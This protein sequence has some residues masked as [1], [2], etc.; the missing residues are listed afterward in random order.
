[1]FPVS[2]VMAAARTGGPAVVVVLGDDMVG[3]A[4]AQ[5]Q[6]ERAWIT[7]VALAGVWRNRGIGSV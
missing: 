2:E 3:M 1:M 4:V 6:G 7:L 5:A